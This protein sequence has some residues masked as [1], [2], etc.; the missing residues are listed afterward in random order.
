MIKVCHIADHLTGEVDGVYSHI[1]SVIKLTNK[2]KFEHYL[3]FQGNKKI[4]EEI[5]GLGGKIIILPQL[6]S[7]LPLRAIIQFVQIVRKNKID[8]VHSHFLKSYIVAGLGNIMLKKKLIYNYHG[9]F[10]KN[11]YYNVFERMIYRLFHSIVCWL[12]SV[13]VA[14]VPSKESMNQLLLETKLFPRI[15][16][17][18]NGAINEIGNNTLDQ[19]IV[20]KIKAVESFK[21]VYVGRIEAEK[22]IDRVIRIL[23]YLKN[24]GI[25]VHLFIFG[26]GNLENEIVHLIDELELNNDVSLLGV[27]PHPANY[28]K[29]FDCL[30]LT[31]DREGMP[32]VVWESM[33]KGLPIVSSSVGGMTEV[34]NDAGSGLLFK[35]NNISEG[36]EKVKLLRNNIQLRYKLGSN[37]KRAIINEYN[38]EKFKKFIENLYSGLI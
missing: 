35:K 24:D 19:S 14:I 6:T 12:N 26:S 17:Y 33:S 37:G 18:Y 5:I 20:A 10:I 38:I 27:G 23:K 13:Q 9:L 21:L 22:R 8:I 3:C 16:Q 29:F 36:V 15:A 2:Q 1:L 7:K 25:R 32:F 31:S 11:E 4:E 34:L 30:I 28:F